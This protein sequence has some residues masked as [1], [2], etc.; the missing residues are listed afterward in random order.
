MLGKYPSP[1]DLF[2]AEVL[3]KMFFYH[4]SAVIRF[5]KGRRRMDWETLLKC[6]GRV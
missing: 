1:E 3:K 4:L 6:N 5:T 2:D